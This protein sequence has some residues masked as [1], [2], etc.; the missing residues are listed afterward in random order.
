MTVKNDRGNVGDGTTPAS[1][2]Y[3]ARLRVLVGKKEEKNAVDGNPASVAGRGF[4]GAEHLDPII[5]C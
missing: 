2:R 4:V 5:C 3:A 1:L